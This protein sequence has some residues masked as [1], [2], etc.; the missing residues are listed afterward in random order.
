MYLTPQTNISQYK[1]EKNAAKRF[2]LTI[3]SHTTLT[4]CYKESILFILR[5]FMDRPLYITWTVDL[6]LA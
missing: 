5:L 2:C 4:F 3:Y 1:V 6:R